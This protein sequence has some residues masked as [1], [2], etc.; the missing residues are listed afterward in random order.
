MEQSSRCRKLRG[1]VG[2]HELGILEFGYW[3]PKLFAL[4]DVL[5]CLVEAA[6]CATDRT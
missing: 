6:L 3:L 5:Y 1:H 2:E 4:L